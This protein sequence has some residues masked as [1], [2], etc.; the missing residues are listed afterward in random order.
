MRRTRAPDNA[1]ALPAMVDTEAG[2]YYTAGP[3]ATVFSADDANMIQEE[4]VAIAGLL[5]VALDT[6]GANTSQC[7]TA[8]AGIKAIVAKNVEATGVDTLWSMAVIASDDA[9]V[10]EDDGGVVHCL[11]AASQNSS[12]KGFETAAIACT[13]ARAGN[14]GGTTD[15]AAVIASED[16]ATEGDHSAI[17]ASH[18]TVGTATAT[19]TRGAIIASTF[20]A[21]LT[22]LGGN[23]VA[24]IATQDSLVDGNNCAIVGGYTNTVDDAAGTAERSVILGGSSNAIAAD[25]SAIVGG[26]SHVIAASDQYSAIIGGENNTID[27]ATGRSNAIVAATNSTVTGITSAVVGGDNNAIT[28]D[29]T[30][31]VI[32]GGE[33]NTIE[34]NFGFIAASQDS[35][36]QG[37]ANCAVLG[38][39]FVDTD[40]GGNESN[41]MVCG[42]YDAG[43]LVAPEWLIKS[44]GGVIYATNTTVQAADYAEFFPNADGSAHAPGRLLARYGKGCKLAGRGA[45]VLGVVSVNPT[46]LGNADELTWQGTFE[47]DE[48]GAFVRGNVEETNRLPPDPV[49]I[50][51]AR[52]RSKALDKQR[53]GLAETVRKYEK[54]ARC[55]KEQSDELAAE[56][57][58]AT[59]ALAALPTE[60]DL[61]D[62]DLTP[63]TERRMVNVRLKSPAFDRSRRKHTPRSRRP[64][65]WTKVGLLGQVRVAVDATVQ[66]E[67]FVVPGDEPGTGTHSD[68]PG[69]GRPIECME[70]VSPF[71]KTR[72]YAIAFCLV[73]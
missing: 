11:V 54:V 43:A 66:A 30:G 1:V 3:P 65:E 53:R 71:D 60:P 56:A 57:A 14:A 36:I 41:Y 28:G 24:L 59:V 10:G 33:D 69:R 8:L 62:L 58:A 7:A 48:W 44:E 64:D 47:R 12:A 15:S 70:I 52:K 63:R 13:D 37:V 42:G 9:T 55:D 4:L 72:G 40:A 19:G 45:R 51:E 35:V 61:S 22:Y 50:Q 39:R 31:A 29:R 67:S 38:S 32:A 73:G 68:E 2:G 46:V 34:N 18:A 27:S 49:A 21:S 23:A 25:D 5:G 16:V 20:G 26:T 6:T 17:I